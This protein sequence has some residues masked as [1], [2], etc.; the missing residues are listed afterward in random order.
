[1][2]L[3]LRLDGALLTPATSSSADVAAAEA[4]PRMKHMMMAHRIGGQ[5]DSRNGM[6]YEPHF[7]YKIPAVERTNTNE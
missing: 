3:V 2:A 5:P 1:M 7:S 4:P 6:R